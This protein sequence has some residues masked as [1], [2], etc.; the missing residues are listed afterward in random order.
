VINEHGAKLGWE[1][2][3]FMTEG[4]CFKPDPCNVKR[5]WILGPGCTVPPWLDDETAIL[6]E[7]GMPAAGAWR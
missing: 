6:M 4:E 5:A 2:A 1:G 7:E 3:V